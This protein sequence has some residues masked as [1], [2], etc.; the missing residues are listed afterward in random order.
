M[1]IPEAVFTAS[2]AGSMCGE[3]LSYRRGN[4][5]KARVYPPERDVSQEEPKIGVY[6]C[7]FGANNRKKS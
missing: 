2:G 3:M 5:S 7:P 4:L 1:D 6:V